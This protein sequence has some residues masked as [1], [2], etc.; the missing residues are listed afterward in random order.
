MKEKFD[1]VNFEINTCNLYQFEDVDYL[2]EKRKEE[3]EN[4]KKKVIEMLDAEAAETTRRKTKVNYAESNMCPNIYSNGNVGVSHDAKKKKLSKVT[5]FRFFPDPDRLRQLIEIEMESKYSNYLT[6]ADVPTFTPEMK[7]EKELIESKG[8][9]D[10]DRREYQKFVQALE[11]YATDDFVNINKHIG[12]TK[13]VIEVQKYAKVFFEKVDTLHDGAKIMNRIQKAQ[14]NVSF[15]MKAPHL[16]RKKVQ[17]YL[18]PEDEMNFVHATQKSKFFSKESDVILM[19]LTDKHGYGNWSDIKKAL[20]RES[21]CRFD[22]LL[23]TRTE[24]ELKK[25]VTYLVQSLEKEDNE[26]KLERRPI[27]VNDTVHINDDYLEQ[28]MKEAEMEATRQL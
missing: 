19:M 12:D 7:I 5:D 13:T 11:L 17:L 27:K 4:M 26:G 10:W 8:F 16:I 14:K 21:R 18:N 28:L 15:N 22:H 2:K 25:R 1:M 3:D 23:V 9:P 20:K 6:G 24:E